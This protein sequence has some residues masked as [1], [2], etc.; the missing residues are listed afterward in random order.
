MQVTLRREIELSKCAI[1]VFPS[2]SRSII[3]K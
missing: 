2:V 3:K 1:C